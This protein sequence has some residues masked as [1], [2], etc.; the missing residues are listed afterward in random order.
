MICLGKEKIFLAILTAMV[1]IYIASNAN[2]NLSKN[3]ENEGT[4]IIYRFTPHGII[5]INNDTDFANQAAMEGWPGNGSEGNPYI[6]SGLEIDAHGKGN[7]IYIGNTTSYFIVENCKLY[8]ASYHSSPYHEGFGITLYKVKN[9]KIYNNTIYENNKG[10]YI[11]T[12]SD[13]IISSNQISNNHGHGITI[14]EYSGSNIIENNNISNNQ[15][16]GIYIDTSSHNSIKNNTIYGN[17]NYPVYLY[18]SSSNAI[19]NNTISNNGN[20]L[21]I[22]SGSRNWIY[23]NM[24]SHNNGSNSTYNS[25]HIQAKDDGSYNHWNSSQYGNYWLDW[26]K[27]NDTNDM[28][29]DGFVDWAYKLDGGS[30]SRDSHPLKNYYITRPMAPINLIAEG[31]ENYVNL[32]WEN[33]SP[34]SRNAT[35]FKVYRN[36]VLL[37]TTSALKPWYNDTGVSTGVLYRYYVKA[38]NYLGES[39]KSNE[40]R[41]IPGSYLRGLIEWLKFDNGTGNI[42][43]D[44]SGHGNDAKIIGAKWTEGVINKALSFDGTNDYVNC[45]KL[46]E[47]M[48]DQQVKS[49]THAAWVKFTNLNQEGQITGQRQSHIHSE[50]QVE[51]NGKVHF[52]MEDD[53]DTDYYVISTN[54][55]NDGNWHFIVGS[56][57][58]TSS[59]MQIWVDGVLNKEY[60][61]HFT[62]VGTI[63][64]FYVGYGDNSY[65]RGVVDNVMIYERALN[66]DEVQ[67]L[68]HSVLTPPL[69]LSA[70]SS[71]GYVNITWDAPASNG[72]SPIKGYTVY[73]DGV[74]ISYVPSNHM[75]YNDTNVSSDVYVYQVSAINADTESAKSSSVTGIPVNW[76]LTDDFSSDSGR[77]DYYGNARYNNSEGYIVLTPD[78]GSQKGKVFL[79]NNIRADHFIVSF[80]YYSS[81][82]DGMTFM[83]YKNTSYTM[84]GGGALGFGKN[85]SGYGI[86]MDTYKNTWDPSSKHIAI[87]NDSVQSHLRYVNDSRVSDSS[88]HTMVVDVKSSEIDVYLDGALI[89]NY[90]GQINRDFGGIGFSSATG[91]YHGKHLIDDVKIYAPLTPSAPRNL[92]AEGGIGYI[93]LSWDAPTNSGT[94]EVSEYRIYRNGTPIAT[95]P[96]SRLWYNDTDVHGGINYTYQVTAINSAG[97]SNRSAVI[98]AKPSGAVPE[99]SPVAM[100]AAAVLIVTI[101][102]LRKKV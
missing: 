42:A 6:I 72:S 22:N 76:T 82:A 8:N 27:N 84:V 83:F 91:Y 38:V 92:S 70:K 78:A 2:M 37:G 45:Q 55:L 96:A 57:N 20:L 56:Y 23:G 13:N 35:E 98:T 5:R 51:T 99:F 15:W 24:F 9:G 34:E 46:A 79:K 62:P 12:S 89:L 29:Q 68:Y 74:N 60:E 18:S 66:A 75:W 87:I 25:S 43:Y 58:Y 32:S 44:Y 14:Y 47:Y 61:Y 36:D 97:E 81:G 71:E 85:A 3:T 64:N 21:Y 4:T 93:N 39:D 40:V 41:I 10:I 88:W 11:Y 100:M 102:W 50:L 80:R 65:F 26:A 53:S 16:F 73:R 31:R 48:S 7:S 49:I 33:P 86:E 54:P 63:D 77:W 59:R 30:G 1:L 90:T 28:N 52:W 95:V 101:S 19:I 94:D 69:N 17:G 67:S